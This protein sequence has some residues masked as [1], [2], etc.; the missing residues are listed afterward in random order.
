[1]PF[2]GQAG[3]GMF[4][5]GDFPKPTSNTTFTP[6]NLLFSD[7]GEQSCSRNLPKAQFS[8]K[9]KYRSFA[10]CGVPGWPLKKQMSR[11][12]HFGFPKH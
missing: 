2:L 9:D 5:A 8:P 6:E 11:F 1:M 7:V 4:G 12:S 10:S 3:S